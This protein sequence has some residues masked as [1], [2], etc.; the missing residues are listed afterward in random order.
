MKA[1]RIEKYRRY[2]PVQRLRQP[3][4]LHPRVTTK[5]QRQRDGAQSLILPVVLLTGFSLG[6]RL[7]IQRL[8]GAVWLTKK[9][10]GPR[11]GERFSRRL[12]RGP[13]TRIRPSKKLRG[14]QILEVGGQ[15]QFRGP[16]SASPLESTSTDV[17][18][19]AGGA[20]T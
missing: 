9:P 15:R 1:L 17:P 10:V 7:W 16:R 6:G 2:E 18:Q 8:H 13:P 4:A 12:R 19:G 11:Q 3:R 14:D 20:S 5:L